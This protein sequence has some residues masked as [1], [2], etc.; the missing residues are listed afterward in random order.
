MNAFSDRF[1]TL[2][3]KHIPITATTFPEIIP[4]RTFEC[5]DSGWLEDSEDDSD[6]ISDDSDIMSDDSDIMSDDEEIPVECYKPASTRDVE[7]TGRY[8]MMFHSLLFFPGFMVVVG[9]CL[10]RLV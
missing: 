10:W 8:C 5:S 3:R 6:I 7:N 1:N 2:R 9:L 4:P